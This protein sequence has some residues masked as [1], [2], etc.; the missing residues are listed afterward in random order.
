VA[1]VEFGAGG[2]GLRSRDYELRAVVYEPQNHEFGGSDVI[3]EI[4]TNG[5]IYK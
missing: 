3:K 4:Q 2:E 5:A 1:G